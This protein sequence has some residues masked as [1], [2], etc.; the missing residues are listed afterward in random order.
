ME[1]TFA[2]EHF[3]Q[4]EVGQATTTT[5]IKKRIRINPLLFNKEFGY[6]NPET[7]GDM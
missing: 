5:R 6:P 7:K 2:L 4:E 3:A 1:Q